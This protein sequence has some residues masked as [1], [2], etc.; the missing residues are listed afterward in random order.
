MCQIKSPC[1]DLDH[2]N[3][4]NDTNSNEKHLKER[5]KKIE[6]NQDLEIQ[7]N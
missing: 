6:K 4:E 2:I 1:N 5:K 3:F 7:K